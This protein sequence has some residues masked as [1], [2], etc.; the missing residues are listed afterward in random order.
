MY[1]EACFPDPVGG[2]RGE[3]VLILVT[4]EI[5]KRLLGRLPQKELLSVPRDSSLGIVNHDTAITYPGGNVWGI[6]VFLW[7]SSLLHSYF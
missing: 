1:S 6:S 2:R 3:G 5:A 4:S 7:H